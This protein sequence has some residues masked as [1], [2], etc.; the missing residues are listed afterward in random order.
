[1]TIFCPILLGP[2]QDYVTLPCK[3]QFDRKE[4]LTWLFENSR[5]PLCQEPTRLR[6]IASRF[7]LLRIHVSLCK[8]K[9]LIIMLA[10][11]G[12]LLMNYFAGSNPLASG[13]LICK[14]LFG[15]ILSDIESSFRQEFEKT[16]NPNTLQRF[17][18]RTMELGI[19]SLCT[20]TILLTLE[21]LFG[22]E[23]FA[24]PELLL[25]DAGTLTLFY[26]AYILQLARMGANFGNCTLLALLS[27]LHVTLLLPFILLGHI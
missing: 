16:P 22:S 21:A 8:R 25:S 18:M 15:T 6:D 19:L 27:C 20:G 4:I 12:A 23:E 10:C 17:G 11:N 9:P 26:T 3:H 14:H 2:T 24:I 5:C 13:I 1:M 7:T